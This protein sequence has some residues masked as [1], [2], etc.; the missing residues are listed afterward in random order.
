MDPTRESI[1][2]IISK[3][4][5]SKATNALHTILLHHEYRFSI[6]LYKGAISFYPYVDSFEKEQEILERAFN[7]FFKTGL[8]RVDVCANELLI[9]M[10][11][12]HPTF[13]PGTGRGELP[14]EDH[15]AFCFL[16]FAM[17][18][19]QMFQE[20]ERNGVFRFDER[21]LFLR[22]QKICLVCKK[23]SKFSCGRCV[24]ALY[25]GRVC[26]VADWKKHQG[27]CKKV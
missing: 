19:L 24:G 7:S 12:I 20:D 1:T 18:K 13:S 11:Q 27:N 8:G 3:T 4:I 26:Q 6:Y 9:R 17:L 22:E 21:G 25:C 23:P 2:K 15:F 5:K 10:A 14:A 16:V